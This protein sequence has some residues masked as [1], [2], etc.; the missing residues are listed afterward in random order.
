MKKIIGIYTIAILLIT[1]GFVSCKKDGYKNDGGQ[2]NPNVN[3]TT[4]D[5]LKS[6]PLFDSLVRII[7][8]AGMKDA[9]NGD[10]T[11]FATTNYGAKDFVTARKIRN[12][13]ITGDENKPFTIDSLPVSEMKDS[14]K[15]YIYPGKIN[16]AQMT[17]EGALYNSALGPIPNIGFLIKLRRTQDYSNYLDHVDYVNFTK[18]IGTR[19]DK[20]LDQSSIPQDQRDFSYD[21]QTSGIITTTGIVHVLSGN[22]RL[23]FNTEPTN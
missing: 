15:M 19:D 6:N 13:V 12:G 8:H 11:F 17:V 23:F 2:S 5:Y 1:T 10:I 7:D 14:I 3:M 16:R 18:V 22:H 9:I 4:Y 20:E 21:C